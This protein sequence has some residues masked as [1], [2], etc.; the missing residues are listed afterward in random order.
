MELLG[1]LNTSIKPDY[2]EKGFINF[3]NMIF[4]E[5]GRGGGETIGISSFKCELIEKTT[6]SYKYNVVVQEEISSGHFVAY[7]MINIFLKDNKIEEF[8]VNG[9]NYGKLYD[10]FGDNFSIYPEQ[11]IHLIYIDHKMLPT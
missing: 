3:N 9:I 2:D 7:G 4:F 1:Y 6:N 10:K 8:F 11:Y 5:D